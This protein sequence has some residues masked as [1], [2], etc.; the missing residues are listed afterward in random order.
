MTTLDDNTISHESETISCYIVRNQWK[1]IE[2]LYNDMKQA[3]RQIKTND[4]RIHELEVLVNCLLEK[5]IK[6]I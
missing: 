5:Q 2:M 4:E 6:N 1:K 3:E